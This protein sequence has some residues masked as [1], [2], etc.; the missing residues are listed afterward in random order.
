[1]GQY[2]RELNL[3]LSRLD[4]EYRRRDSSDVL[5]RRYSHFNESTLLHSQSLERNLLILLKRH[6]FTDLAEKKFWMLAV[7][8]VVT[9]GI[10]WNMGRFLIISSELI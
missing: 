6:N 7:A 1:M 8:V 2:T 5:A 10:S 4:A 9:C 3:E